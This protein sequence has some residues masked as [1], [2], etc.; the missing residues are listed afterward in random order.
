MA[1]GRRRVGF[2]ATRASNCIVVGERLRV[3]C[4]RLA[5]CLYLVE[6]DIVMALE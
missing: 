5:D 3:L 2:V 4:E 1:D 6:V